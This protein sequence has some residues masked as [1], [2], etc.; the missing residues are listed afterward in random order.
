MEPFTVECLIDFIG[1]TGKVF[2]INPRSLGV[3]IHK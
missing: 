1:R 3:I 2:N